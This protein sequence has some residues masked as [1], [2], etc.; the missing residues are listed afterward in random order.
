MIDQKIIN[1]L[2]KLLALS[3]SD[4]E[5]EAA[6]AMKKA[7]DYNKNLKRVQNDKEVAVRVQSRIVDS[8]DREQVEA[9]VYGASGGERFTKATISKAGFRVPTTAEAAKKIGMVD[10]GGYRYT[11]VEG[12]RR[13][14][15]Y[16]L[17]IRIKLNS[18]GEPEGEWHTDGER[19]TPV[20]E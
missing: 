7:E 4:N 3:A 17:V 2:Q 10:D 12:L 9:L 8:L 15:K 19:P 11:K 16:Q 1:K 14:K 18:R 5:N 6:L 13:G 20:G